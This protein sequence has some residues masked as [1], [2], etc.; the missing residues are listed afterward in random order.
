LNYT[1]IYSDLI[2][3]SLNRKISDYTERHHIIPVS[4]KGTNDRENIAILTAREHYVAHYLLCKIYPTNSK[5]AQGLWFMSQKNMHGTLIRKYKITARAYEQARIMF[6]KSM[7]GYIHTEETRMKMR[8]K[9]H[10]QESGKIFSEVQ[11]RLIAEEDNN[12]I[13]RSARLKSNLPHWTDGI[14]EMRSKECPGTGWY[15]GRLSRGVLWWN[16]GTLCK[17]QKESPGVEWKK[18]RIYKS[19]GKNDYS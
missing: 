11:K 2:H 16:N 13:K 18:G 10:T 9:K 12:G 19:R 8:G 1:K 4:M 14:T 6:I 17:M 5:L 15:N 7:E 3:R